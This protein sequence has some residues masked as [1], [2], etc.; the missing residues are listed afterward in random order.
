MIGLI[1]LGVVIATFSFGLHQ[2]VN[3]G[4]NKMAVYAAKEVFSRDLQI[5]RLKVQVNWLQKENNRL[6][7]KG[8]TLTEMVPGVGVAP[9]LNGF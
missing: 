8:V 7:L 6:R 9:T 4:I 3:L 5:D 2:G 1:S